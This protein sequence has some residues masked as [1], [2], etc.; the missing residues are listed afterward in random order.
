MATEVIMPKAGMAMERGTIIQWFKKPGDY[1]EAGEPLLEIETDKV[2]ME[3][4]SEVSGYLLTVLHREGDEVE[5]IK[6]IGYIGEKDEEPPKA[7]RVQDHTTPGPTSADKID[8]AD[9]RE[10]QGAGN[11]KADLSGIDHQAGRA[12][13]D[14]VK[15]T[16]AARRRSWELGL[17][18]D[19]AEPTG[20][21]GEIR[22]RDIEKL[23][24]DVPS[25]TADTEKVKTSPLAK[26]LAE[27]ESID[28]SGMVGSGPGGRII[29]RDIAE[30][31]DLRAGLE[32]RPPTPSAQ[33]TG[34]TV[35]RQRLKGIRKIIAERM[36]QSHCIVPPVTLNRNI[37]VDALFDLR[38]QINEELEAKVSI[39]DII[40]KAVAIALIDSP[41]MR[42]T[43]EGSELVQMNEINIG[44]AVALEEGLLV[45]VVRNADNLSLL[46]LSK[47][48]NRLTTLAKVRKLD[49][50]E[51]QGAA[52][53]VTNLGMYGIHSFNPIINLPQSGI[54]GVGAASDELYL[55][56][57]EVQCKKVMTLSLTIDHRV[58]DGAQ[59][60][61]FLDKIAQLLEKPLKII[62]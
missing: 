19:V 9:N 57:G 20:S 7:A 17:S 6:P 30:Q 25:P 34:Q 1:V 49:P 29:K 32:D 62:V 39:T 26:K 4:E 24:S 5:V 46:S 45:P 60:A 56:D 59:G 28:L 54:L 61:L 51:L 41:Y 55:E 52:F 3:V 27:Q 38:R 23:A 18:L 50:D 12:D 43:I 53:T 14:R 13:P 47:E 35:D 58:V 44:I 15:A 11:S 10:S 2:A 33:F 22:L 8:H 42:T 36:S 37:R 40:V 31:S 48:A 16:P 21:W